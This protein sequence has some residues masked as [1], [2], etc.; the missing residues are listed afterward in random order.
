MNSLGMK[1]LL[2]HESIET[3]VR[4][5]INDWGL[6]QPEGIKLRNET[7][8]IFD[9]N[10]SLRQELFMRKEILL[11]KLNESLGVTLKDIKISLRRR[12]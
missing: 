4:K 8:L 12:K 3:E 5:I 6:P 7:L 11:K 9:S 2:L 1:G 10:A